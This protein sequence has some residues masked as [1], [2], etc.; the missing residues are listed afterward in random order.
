MDEWTDVVDMKLNKVVDLIR[1]PKGTVVRLKVVPASA[2]DSSV[3]AEIQLTRDEIKLTAQEA[4]AKLVEKRDEDGRPALLGY[5]E[6]PS[7]Y[8]DT[9]KGPT[10]KSA[11]RDVSR[12]I[13]RLKA[14][15]ADGLLID[16]RRNTGGSLAE[17]I[18]MT[19]LFIPEGPVV[20]VKDPYGR[21]HA[22]RDEDGLTAYD[23]PLVVLVS[24]L[25]AS[26]AEIF[27]AALQDYGRAIIVGDQNT[28]GKGTVQQIVEL[29]NVPGVRRTG[30]GSS[31]ALKLTIQK[32]YRVSGGSTQSRGVVPDIQL[33]SVFDARPIGE[34]TLPNSLPYDEVRKS[35]YKTWGVITQYLPELRAH[36]AQRL[37]QNPEFKYLQ[38]DIA[39]T[40]KRF[41]EKTISL[42]QAQREAEKKA[43][44]DRVNAR[45][46]ER[47]AR[48]IEPPRSIEITLENLDGKTNGVA[49]V[50]S[51]SPVAAASAGSEDE[52]DATDDPSVDTVFD[53]GLRILTDYVGMVSV[54]TAQSAR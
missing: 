5:I 22:Q 45:K 8:V 23:G 51:T 1:G 38:E 29:D 33:P 4:K 7:F 46:K 36:C 47:I 6:L 19:G 26:A 11:T 9:K 12:L 44:Q 40:K 50:S 17:A 20:Q 21:V 24:H 13:N 25:S 10:A 34:A 32:F 14:S 49:A 3:R 37:V 31:G 30:A 52:P 42:N 53:E 41:D 39:R 28:F 27:A 35:D 54:M 16:L 48:K 15:S 2:P 43:N 18:S